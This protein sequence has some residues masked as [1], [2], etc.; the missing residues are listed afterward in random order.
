MGKLKRINIR[1]VWSN[2]A[3]DFTPWLAENLT[4]L[5]EVISMG[6]EAIQREADIGDF[7]VDLLAKDLGTGKYV[8]VE[9]QFSLTDH[10]HLGKQITCG[11]GYDVY[12]VIWIA[13]QIREEHRQ[14]LDWL[15]QRTDDDTLFFGITI[16]VL[17]INNSSPT[18]NF[19]PVVFPNEWQK[20]TLRRSQAPSPRAEAY[21]VFFQS[22]IDDLR[23]KHRIS[24]NRKAKP[25][26]W[27]QLGSGFT[28]IK[29]GLN[30][31]RGGKTCI[32]LWIMYPDREA[33]KILFDRLLVNKTEIED[34]I[35]FDL[36]WERLEDQD[37]CR[38]ATRRDGSID[39]ENLV[40]IK[41]WMSERLIRFRKVFSPLIQ[42]ELDHQDSVQYSAQ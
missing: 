25:H 33:N 2:E 22:V 37:G 19:K 39:N 21:R 17:K 42:R 28:S 15:N 41:E 18:I 6:L 27:F 34:D 8:I 7:S 38:I 1:E 26:N 24:I 5:A 11:A 3:R 20:S 14:G 23:E 40:D 30:F 13:K 31:R 29:Y 35:G 10:D 36:E 4:S 32:E 9:N 16:E 12:A